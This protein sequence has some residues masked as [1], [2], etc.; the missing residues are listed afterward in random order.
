MSLN[1]PV[2][3]NTVAHGYDGNQSV[4]RGWNPNHRQEPFNGINSPF[5]RAGAFHMKEFSEDID[6]AELIIGFADFDNNGT[7]SKDELRHVMKLIKDFSDSTELTAEE[8]PLLDRIAGVIRGALRGFK[9]LDANNDGKLTYAS[10]TA[11]DASEVAKAAATAGDKTKFDTADIKRPQPFLPINW[12]GINTRHNPEETPEGAVDLL[13]NNGVTGFLDS[14]ETT[15]LRWNTSKIDADG[16]RVMTEVKVNKPS[17][18]KV[19]SGDDDL[20]DGINIDDKIKVTVDDSG[21]LVVKVDGEEVNLADYAANRQG[22][23]IPPRLGGYQV[24]VSDD[25]KTFSL[26]TGGGKAYTISSEM[27][28]TEDNSDTPVPTLRIRESFAFSFAE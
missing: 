13:D 8:K 19:T 1:R 24:M 22:F 15:V 12:P 14:G 18:K 9:T 11:G 21:K 3:R 6:V 4:S 10:S 23:W 17:D 28:K 27:V 26:S 25:G 5:N 16:N 7:T 20:I 2:A